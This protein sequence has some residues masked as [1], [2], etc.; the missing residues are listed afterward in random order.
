MI[1]RL[2]SKIGRQG[3]PVLGGVGFFLLCFLLFVYLTFPYDRLRDYIVSRVEDPPGAVL[4]P[5]RRPKL[6][7]GELYPSWLTGVTLKKIEVTQPPAQPSGEPITLAFDE[8]TLRI[9]PLRLLFGTTRLAFGGEVGD[10]EV[11][12]VYTSKEGYTEVEFEADA[13]DLRRTLPDGVKGM[14]IFGNLTG[15][16]E[17]VLTEDPK[18]SVGSVALAI[19]HAAFGDGK[20][21]VKLKGTGFAIDKVRAGDLTVKAA[22]ENGV[23]RIQELRSTGGDLQAS[24]K[25]TVRLTQPLKLS[26]PDVLLRLKLT[27]DYQKKHSWAQGLMALAKIDP[28]QKKMVTSD[29]AFQFRLRGTMGGS[30]RAIAAA[31]EPRP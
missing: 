29:G 7:V 27:D 9:S 1:R 19:S 2:W 10:G 31:S 11:D 4:P 28:A 12:G 8:L 5:S 6:R 30:L 24:G 18:D 15:E 26:S 23:A 22:I 3:L 25:G 16:G 17:V 13:L 14:P 20:A 21:E